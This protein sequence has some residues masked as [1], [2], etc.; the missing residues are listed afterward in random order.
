MTEYFIVIIAAV[1]G[2]VIGTIRGMN[3]ASKEEKCRCLEC[4][5]KELQRHNQKEEDK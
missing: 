5:D 3:S 2:T 4:A 1:V